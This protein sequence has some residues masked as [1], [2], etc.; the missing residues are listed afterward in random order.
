MKKRSMKLHYRS[1]RVSLWRKL[2]WNWLFPKNCTLFPG[3]AVVLQP[4]PKL[5]S[6]ISKDL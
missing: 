6:Y 2:K 3:G 1:F 4:W 5:N